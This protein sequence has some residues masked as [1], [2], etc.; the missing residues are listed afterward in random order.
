VYDAL[1]SERPYKAPWPHDKAL[2][3]IVEQ[4]GRQFDPELVKLFHEHFESF[5]HR[6]QS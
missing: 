1:I 3:Y 4:S 5:M 6:L 2:A